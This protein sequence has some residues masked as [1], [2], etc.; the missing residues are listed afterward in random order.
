MGRTTY[1]V[2]EKLGASWAVCYVERDKASGD[3]RRTLF[4]AGGFACAGGV[5]YGLDGLRGA[6]DNAVRLVFGRQR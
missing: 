6:A 2:P 5:F 3:A 1:S 4:F